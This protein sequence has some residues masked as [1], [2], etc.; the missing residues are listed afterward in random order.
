MSFSS[1]TAAPAPKARYEILDGLRGVAAIAVVIFHLFEAHAGGDVFAQY[2]NHGYLAVDFFFLLSGFVLGYAYDDQWG[3]MS[4][5]DFARR[6]LIRL[7]PMVVV[8]TV[9][10]AACFYFGASGMFPLIAATPFWK[11]VL[12]SGLGMLMLPLPVAADI[13]GWQ[14]TY[15]LNG[16]AWSLF[17]EYIANILYA[18]VLRRISRTILIVLVLL[19]GAVTFHYL[20]TCR[21]GDIIGGW[22]L[23]S[24]QLRIGFTRLAYP[25]LAGL[26]LFRLGGKLKVRHGFWVCALA[27]LAL[28]ALPRLGTRESHWP[29]ALYE[30]LCITLLFPMVVAAGAGSD[31][32]GTRSR[33][34][35]LFLGRISYPIYITHY[36]IIYLYTAWVANH[37]VS[38]R[39]GFPTATLAFA[40][41][42][43]IAWLSLRF[44]DEPVRNA[45]TSL[46]RKR[47]QPQD[48]LPG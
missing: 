13:R 42:L 14:E 4:Y 11:L 48:S 44:Y 46:T 43:A 25:F 39:D 32:I 8:G 29:N 7:Q 31:L 9:I 33:Q 34:F 17:F 22:S 6:R 12:F 28:L 26:L 3:R 45:L 1:P 30:G 40:A 18:L 27:L 38:I 36:P 16:P 20:L 47:R 35:C 23:N 5:L 24:E 37:K 41:I 2:L 15:P 19:T 21:S 10:G